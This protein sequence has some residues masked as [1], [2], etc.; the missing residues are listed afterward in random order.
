MCAAEGCFWGLG[1]LLGAGIAMLVFPQVLKATHWFHGS[2]EFM[3][4]LA[5]S[6]LLIFLLQTDVG[7]PLLGQVFSVIFE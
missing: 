6:S 5:A 7:V 1:S 4:A 3:A 2:A